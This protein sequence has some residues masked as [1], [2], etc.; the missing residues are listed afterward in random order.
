MIKKWLL[1]LFCLFHM[2][3]LSWWTLPHGFGAMV[4]SE[5]KPQALEYKL[6]KQLDRLETTGLPSVFEAY[7][8][9]TGSQQYW[10]F[11]APNSP[12][13]HQYL[14]LCPAIAAYPEQGNISC[15]GK[16]WFSSLPDDAAKFRL[17]GSDRSRL[18]R[19]TE[20]LINLDD[21]G[22]LTAFAKYYRSR[23]LK[24]ADSNVPAYLIAHQ[25]ELHPELSDLA[26]AG[27]REDKLLLT[28]P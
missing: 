26:K 22:L 18:Y 19:L 11:F 27:Y 6:F 16:P 3:A 23:K 24:K 1:T 14:S 28:L 5:A 7:I 9:L 8:N 12:R 21:S 25:F 17:F 10:D 13:F 4:L 20:N 2:L 15:Q